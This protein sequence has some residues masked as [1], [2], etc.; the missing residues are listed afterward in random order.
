M[1][2]SIGR[3]GFAASSVS[4]TESAREAMLVVERKGGSSGAVVVRFVASSEAGATALVCRYGTRRT[5]LL[6][7]VLHRQAH[8]AS[9]S[10][11]CCYFVVLLD[12]FSFF[13]F[14]E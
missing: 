9:R 2:D 1:P 4:A 3:I 14:E 5:G 7:H 10:E 8:F 12:L 6:D 13:F 11:Q